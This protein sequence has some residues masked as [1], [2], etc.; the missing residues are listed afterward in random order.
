MR[1]ALAFVLL[2]FVAL[3]ARANG[4]AIVITS[5][6]ATLS[7]LDMPGGAELRRVPVLRE[8][9]HFALSPDGKQLLVG[10]AGGNEMLFLDPGTGE[11]RRRTPVAAPYHLQFSPNGK[12]VVVTGL[13]R[14]QV[15]VYDAGDMHLIKR[16]PASSM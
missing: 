1:F 10:D 7:L 3:P 9:H 12:L 11:I 4:I 6:D 2:L 16:F 15:D 13:A 5:G 8:A 14:N